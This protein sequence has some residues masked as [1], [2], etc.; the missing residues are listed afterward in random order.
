[1]KKIFEFGLI[2][3]CFFLFPQSLMAEDYLKKA[4]A[5]F[6]QGGIDNTKKAIDYFLKAAEAEPNSYEITWKT[7]RAYYEYCDIAVWTEV[8]DWKNICATYAKKGMAMGEK[9]IEINP[10]GVE[11]HFFYGLSVGCYADG[12]SILTAL[13]EG[14]KG[15]TQR[16]FEK[17]Y[18]I[19]K[20]YEDAAPIIANGRFWSVLPWPLK[21]RNTAIEYYKEAYSFFPDNPEILIYYGELLM[22]SK[23]DRPEAKQMLEKAAASDD[24][25][26]SEWAKQLLNKF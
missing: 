8:G 7:S 18:K 9:A 19:D 2:F 1:M 21:N 25:Y 10:K 13:R 14:L 6:D 15:K 22:E 23:R 16:A 3:F 26:F 17:S 11:G 24:S 5:L 12:V 4:D 20:M